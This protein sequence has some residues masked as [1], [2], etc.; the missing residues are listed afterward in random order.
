MEFRQVIQFLWAVL[1]H[2]NLLLGGVFMQILNHYH[3]IKDKAVSR[4]V[5]L[6]ASVIFILF[7]V[8][9]TWQDQVELRQSAETAR[10]ASEQKV[11]YE[12]HRIDK[13]SDSL[14]PLK[15]QIQNQAASRAAWYFKINYVQCDPPVDPMSPAGRIFPFRIKVKVNS[16][17]V[18]SFPNGLFSY[19]GLTNRL[20]GGGSILLDPNEEQFSIELFLQRLNTPRAQESDLLHSNLLTTAGNDRNPFKITDLPITATNWIPLSE[21]FLDKQIM[22]VYEITTNRDYSP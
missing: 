18:G 13:L 14:E 8:F 4:R 10:E 6:T 22:V 2:W 11:E 7:A 12:Q 19:A 16:Q 20:E 21:R 1:D 15:R 9:F 17:L 3:I 5:F